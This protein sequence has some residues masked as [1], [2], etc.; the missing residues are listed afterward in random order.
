MYLATGAGQKILLQSDFFSLPPAVFA[1]VH[2]LPLIDLGADCD[3]WFAVLLRLS[4]LSS[5][6]FKCFTY[7]SNQIVIQYFKSVLKDAYTSKL[8]LLGG[9]KSAL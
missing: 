7:L 5:L 2:V 8:F 1:A 4:G 3:F 9:K 6:F